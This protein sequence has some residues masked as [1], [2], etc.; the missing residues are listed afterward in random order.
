VVVFLVAR[1]QELVLL[2]KLVNRSLDIC[3]AVFEVADANPRR[4]LLPL[5]V[6]EQVL[7]GENVVEGSE[8]VGVGVAVVV[9]FLI[10]VEESEEQFHPLRVAANGLSRE[11][12]GDQLVAWDSLRRF[13]FQ[14]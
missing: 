14:A 13:L 9:Y 5:K 12:V 1:D 3:P 10:I 4:G 2:L 7:G 8:G 6:G 11:D